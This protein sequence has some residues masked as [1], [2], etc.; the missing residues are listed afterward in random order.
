[1]GNCLFNVCSRLTGNGWIHKAVVI[2]SMVHII[3]EIQVFKAPQP[4][5]NLVISKKQVHVASDPTQMLL[6][7][8]HMHCKKAKHQQGCSKQ[9]LGTGLCQLENQ[10]RII[11]TS[12]L[13]YVLHTS[14]YQSC[15]IVTFSSHHRNRKELSILANALSRCGSPLH[16][17]PWKEKK[18]HKLV[19]HGWCFSYVF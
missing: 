6:V 8:A 2:G 14:L 15:K 5:E 11:L 7:K 19:E 4:V 12:L 18:N 3:E 13:T 16:R 1:M 9:M 17:S 10:F